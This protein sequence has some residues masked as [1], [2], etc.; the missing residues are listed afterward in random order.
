M[1]C[2][3]LSPLLLPLLLQRWIT[4]FKQTKQSSA[5]VPPHSIPTV[6]PSLTQTWPAAINTNT[7]L[8]WTKNCDLLTIALGGCEGKKGR[9]GHYKRKTQ[10]DRKPETTGIQKPG[11]LKQKRKDVCLGIS[12]FVIIVRMCLAKLLYIKMFKSYIYKKKILCYKT[13]FHTAA[14]LGTN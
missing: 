11:F 13:N 8:L 9:D 14:Q 12:V 1:N 5:L 6:H 4:F 7:H 10:E 2:I 3:R